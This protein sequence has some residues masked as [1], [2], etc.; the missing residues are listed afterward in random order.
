MQQVISRTS[1]DIDA[2]IWHHIPKDTNLNSWTCVLLETQA[3]LST[4]Q[5]FPNSL[6]SPQAQYCVSKSLPLVPIL[7]HL[8][9]VHSPHPIS[10]RSVLILSSQLRLRLPSGLLP[11]C[12]PNK[13]LY[14]FYFSPCLL[15]ALSSDPLWLHHSN[16]ITSYNAHHSAVLS[17]IMLFHPSSVQH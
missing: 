4:I 14:A 3:S 9:P 2:I 7:S 12:V 17:D 5:K 15:H 16:F 10:L 8:N 13:T 1:V 11:S 6:W